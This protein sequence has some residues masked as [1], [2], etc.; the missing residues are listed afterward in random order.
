TFVR[1]TE[2]DE[3]TLVVAHKS[4]RRAP[5]P[6]CGWRDRGAP[7]VNRPL[8]GRR[9]VI[10]QETDLD[11]GRRPLGP[12]RDKAGDISLGE[13][14]LHELYRPLAVHLAVDVALGETLL[15]QAE[16][17]FVERHFLGDVAR[18]QDHE[19]Q[20]GHEISLPFLCSATISWSR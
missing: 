18:V 17:V 6:L 8:I 5:W 19:S 15:L 16:R 14:L 10:E 7:S 9:H 4:D 20:L 11:R 3:H 1:R 13:V 2:L 12:I